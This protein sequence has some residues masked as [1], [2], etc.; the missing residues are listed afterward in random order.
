M[1]R[2]LL[3]DNYDSFTYNLAHLFGKLGAQVDVVRNDHPDLSEAAVAAHDGIVIGPGPGR[4]HDAGKTL[5]TIDQAISIGRP[6]FGVC[7]GLQALGEY[8]GGEVT[9][10]P[11][12]MHGK[13]SRISHEGTGIFSGVPSPF[14]ATRYHSLCVARDSLPGELIVTATSEDGVVQGIAHRA[15][16]AVA[17][18]FHP[19]SVL[20]PDG[21]TIFA[22]FLAMLQR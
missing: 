1:S 5:A 21:G 11:S 19:E 3:V 9:Y 2:I 18:Q 13:T 17:V 14:A 12:L 15:L 4:P 10:A 22:N 6:L 16:P 20:T 8:F 7:L